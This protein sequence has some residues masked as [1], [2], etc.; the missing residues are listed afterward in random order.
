MAHSVVCYRC[1]TS[2]AA[3][4]LPLAR[5]DLCPECG[6]ELHVCR[7]CRHF[8]E[9]AVDQCLEEEAEAVREKARANFCDWFVAAERAW[10]SSASREAEEAAARFEEL[11]GGDADTA[12]SES[13]TDP[14]RDEAEK[15]FR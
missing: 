4:S 8:D 7:M 2:L 1:G 12:S 3:F 6:S 11:F 10:D 13:G 9:R 15:L 5:Q 14:L